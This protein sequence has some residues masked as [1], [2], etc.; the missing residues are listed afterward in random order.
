MSWF[1]YLRPHLIRVPGTRENQPTRQVPNGVA[2]CPVGPRVL[3]HS[4]SGRCPA[5]GWTTGI[6]ECVTSVRE[7][8]FLGLASTANP[9]IHGKPRHPRQTQALHSVRGE[10]GG[11]PRVLEAGHGGAAHRPPVCPASKTRRPPASRPEMLRSAWAHRVVP[12]LTV[13][14]LGSPCSAWVCRVV[15]GFAL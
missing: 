11:R 10:A 8:G 5:P 12:G 4:R 9:G 13:W 15:P 7:V 6:L 14:C 2:F 1:V 3:F